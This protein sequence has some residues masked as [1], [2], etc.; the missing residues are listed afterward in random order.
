MAFDLQQWKDAI[1][2]R[3]HEFAQ[4]PQGVTA[5]SQFG[6]LCGMT[7]FPLAEAVGRGDMMGVGMTLGG[8]AAGVG[9]NLVAE[10]VQR[11]VDRTEGEAVLSGERRLAGHGG[12][13]PV[14]Q[15]VGGSRGPGSQ[16]TIVGR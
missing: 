13:G 10:Q 7:L 2:Q 5:G 14:L 8:I 11:W 12:A 9:G 3:I 4:N 1:R 16:Q 15:P 6:F